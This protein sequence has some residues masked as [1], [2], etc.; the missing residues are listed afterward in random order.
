[1]FYENMLT[2]ICPD[3]ADST[4]IIGTEN[5]TD[6]YMNRS[7]VCCDQINHPVTQLPELV[8]F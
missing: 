3:G 6:N 2:N 1:M 7:I 8:R 4:R 5:L